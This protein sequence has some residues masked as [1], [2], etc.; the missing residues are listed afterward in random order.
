MRALCWQGVNR[1]GVED[2]AE[3]QILNDGDAIVEVGLSTTCGSDLHLI[4][5]YIPAMRSGDVLGHEFMGTIVEVGPGVRTHKPGDRVVVS[6]FVSCGRCWYCQ[7]GLFSLCDDGNPNPA[8]TEALW[9]YAPGGC[10]GYSHA[11]GGYAGCHAAYV[12][13]P[14]ADVGAFAIPG[15]VDDES[16]LFASDSAP[17]GWTAVDQSGVGPGDV[18]AVWGA[19]AVGQMTARA[20]MLRGAERVIVIDRLP[21]R[22]AQVT[23]VIGAEVIDAERDDV[24]PELR[25]RT[26]GRGPDV[27]I[28]AVGMEPHPAG[29]MGAVDM[30]KQQLRLQTGRP[31][32]LREVVHGCR[33]GGRVF[34]LGVYVGWVDGFPAG[35]LMNKGL[36]V[37][38]AQ[39]HG[40]RYIPEILGRMEDGSLTT[41]HLATHR[42]SLEDAPLGYELFKS[43]ADGCVRAVFSPSGAL[44]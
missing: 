28:D 21:E 31:G 10:L 44:L 12:R 18:V 24:V 39:M 4:G 40:A 34:I 14:Y 7:Q 17:T 37:Q 42:M 23:D 36:T 32:V 19:G 43:K 6:S 1:L 27:C 41:R 5:G 16:A 2:V 15:G 22:L 11:M 13:V 30:A 3:P 33:K 35:A 25:D 38:G 26:G 9:G 8:I 20:A 29:V